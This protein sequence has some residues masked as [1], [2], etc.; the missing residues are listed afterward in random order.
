MGMYGVQIHTYI[1]LSR[2]DRIDIMTK[3]RDNRASAAKVSATST[4]AGPAVGDLLRI[5][6]LETAA[7]TDARNL[8]NII[9]IQKV[10]LLSKR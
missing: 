8:N 2:K 6:E 5:R 4:A 1:S 7:A 10:V 9:D 3:S